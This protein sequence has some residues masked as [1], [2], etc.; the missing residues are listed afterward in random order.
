MS[1]LSLTD[2]AQL[3]Q[4]SA[5]AD[6]ELDSA[7]AA[8]ACALWHRDAAVRQ[9]WHAYHLIGDV[10][11]SDDL[12]AEP[13]RDAAFLDQLRTRLSHEA[14]VLAPQAPAQ[15]QRGGGRAMSLERR[16]SGIRHAPWLFSSAVAAGLIA[17]VGV[18]TFTRTVDPGVSVNGTLASNEAAT[19]AGAR[20][21]DLTLAGSGAGFGAGF[22]SVATPR[23]AAPDHLVRDARLDAYLAAHKQFAGSSAPRLPSAFLRSADGAGR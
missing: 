20:A 15:A 8:K 12:A 5:L 4:V 23:S 7:A 19:R 17:V 13:R 21:D 10:L 18:F 11:R 16:T 22:G 14:V 6:G 1:T 3:E 2:A 9:S